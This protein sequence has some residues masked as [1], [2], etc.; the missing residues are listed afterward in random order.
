MRTNLLN[1]VKEQQGRFVQIKNPHVSPNSNENLKNWSRNTTL[2]VGDS[3]LPDIEERKILKR[4]LKIKV[5]N[6]PR[7]TIDGMFNYIKQL[8]KKYRDNIILHTGTNITLM[9]QPK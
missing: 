3:M 9:S 5:K 7:A 6:F 4:E 8:L 2:I 1:F